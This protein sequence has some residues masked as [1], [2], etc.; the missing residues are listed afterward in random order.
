MPKVAWSN[1]GELR[2]YNDIHQ[3]HK[4]G[5]I[6]STLPGKI[7][8]DL[9]RAYYSA[10]SFTDSLIGEVMSALKK[11]GLDSNTIVSFWGDHGWQLGK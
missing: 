4:N 6:N 1:Y 2:S 5:A 8:R 9:R 10:L 11:E 3:L 7:V